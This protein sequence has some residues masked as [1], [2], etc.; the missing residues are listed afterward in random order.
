MSYSVRLP[1][2]EGPLDLLLHLIRS[3][4]LDIR[5][6]PIALVTEQYL[7]YL[8]MLEAM[9]LEIAGEFL[10]MASTLMEIKSRMLL[11]RPDPP[12]DED[13]GIDP[14]AE[15]VERLL[16]YERFQQVAEQLRELAAE[17]TR[18]F[19]RSAAEQWEGAVPL[20][21]LR[22]RDLLEAL[23]RMTEP[24]ADGQGN[25]HAAP[26]RVRRQAVSF[27]LRVT[28]IL[29]RVQASAA[30]VLF[31][32]LIQRGGR[33]LAREEVLVTFLA[34]LELL[35]QEAIT[36]WQHAACGEIYLLRREAPAEA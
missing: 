10:V 13:E 31:S 17:S 35:R 25:G 22:P 19:P 28:E 27:R 4:K 23:R 11:P 36:A 20:V 6:I 9:D 29:R 30:P 21:E 26:L 16:E 1:V 8:A 12:R 5:D 7:G 24:A 3:H 15:L 32:T 33:R 18:T 2:F 14:R 34:V